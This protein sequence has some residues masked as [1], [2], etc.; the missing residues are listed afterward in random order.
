VKSASK[1]LRIAQVISNPLTKQALYDLTNCYVFFYPAGVSC[2]IS[3]RDFTFLY[4]NAD[5]DVNIHRD[6][7]I[8]ARN[9]VL[10]RTKSS[11]YVIFIDYLS[12]PIHISVDIPGAFAPKDNMHDPEDPEFPEWINFKPSPDDTEP[13][14][15]LTIKV[16]HGETAELC[17]WRSN[18]AIHRTDAWDQWTVAGIVEGNASNWKGVPIAPDSE[19]DEGVVGMASRMKSSWKGGFR[20]SNLTTSLIGVPTL[21]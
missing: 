7:I 8:K 18:K 6:K 3:D 19:F 16:I 15:F 10:S 2:P 14:V 4:F 12:T 20:R 1:F 5:R 21:M 13:L 11:V 9:N 17:S